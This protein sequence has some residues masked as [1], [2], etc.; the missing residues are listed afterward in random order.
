[1]SHDDRIDEARLTVLMDVRQPFA[2]LALGPTIELGRRQGL[3][4]NWLPA[5]VSPLRRPPPESEGNERS[6]AH[7]RNRSR[8]I[9]REIAIYAE[10]Q[11]LT[12]REYYRD[13]GWSALA[14]GILFVREQAPVALEAFLQAT[15][16]AYWAVELEAEDVGAVAKFV[17]DL[18]GHS[19]G[20]E[21]IGFDE[22]LADRLRIDPF[23]QV[24]DER[25]GVAL[26]RQEIRAI[27][28]LAVEAEARAA[29]SGRLGARGDRP[30]A[31]DALIPGA[32]EVEIAAV[33]VD[34][35]HPDGARRASLDELDARAIR[36]VAAEEPDVGAF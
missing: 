29:R 11:G 10:A 6:V 13:G 30:D 1:M 23:E 14:Q 25:L 16:A 24:E 21:V 31:E 33:D 3:E 12:L 32:R 9:A 7:R 5:S 20:T 36:V 28:A 27:P 26:D 34:V 2:Y 22:G 19:E 35:G 4:I 15:F 8:M 17:G 18:E